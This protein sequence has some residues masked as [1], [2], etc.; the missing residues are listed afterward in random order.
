MKRQST[1]CTKVIERLGFLN[2]EKAD[3]VEILLKGRPAYPSKT[4]TKEDLAQVLS[5]L[6]GTRKSHEFL[7]KVIS[8]RNSPYKYPTSIYKM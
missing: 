4:W 3:V 8:L 6:E 1:R 2:P 5:T 7:E